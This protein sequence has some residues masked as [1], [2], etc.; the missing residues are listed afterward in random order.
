MKN[1]TPRETG[2]GMEEEI[3]VLDLGAVILKQW[4]TVLGI[5]LVVMLLAAIIKLVLPETYTART[6]LIPP[7]AQSDGRAQLIASQLV[8][9]SGLVGGANSSHRLLGA[10]L[11]SRSMADSLVDQL[12]VAGEGNAEIEAEIRKILARDT[13][14]ESSSDGSVVIKVSAEDPE[15][16]ARI[17]NLL[18]QL[19][20]RMVAQIGAQAALRKQ[21]FLENQLVSARRKLEESEQQLIEFQ[22]ARDAPELQDQARRTIDAAADLQQQIIQQEIEVARLRRTVTP[23]NPQLQAAVAELGARREQLR[24]LT[25]G[26][27]DRSQLFLSLGESPELKVASTRLL[28]EYTK[29]EQI[30][31]SLT[32]ALAQAQIDG[33]N[34]LPIVTVLDPAIVPTSPSGVGLGIILSVAALL[35]LVVGL[36]TA[37]VREHLHNARQ[38]RADDPFFAAWDQL[39]ADVMGYMPPRWNGRVRSP[40]HDRKTPAPRPGQGR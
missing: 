33:N 17:A 35:G 1:D 11:K 18:P 6:V 20:N 30:Y 15:R 9:L 8:G 24:R 37:F 38:Q 32:A 26:D 13:E 16:A 7:Q 12:G 22:E 31:V 14:L 39:K 2:T 19:A 21:Q 34:N 10:V 3:R 40:L 27:R 25:S 23:D 4:R 29:N 28:R 36:L 5:V